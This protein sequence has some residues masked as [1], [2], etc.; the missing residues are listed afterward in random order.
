MNIFD[1]FILIVVSISTFY[2]IRYGLIRAIF[3]MLGIIVGWLLAGQLSGL[4]G[5]YLSGTI[6]NESVTTVIAYAIILILSLWISSYAYKVLMPVLTIS[7]LGMSSL[8][9]KLGGALLGLAIGIT[10]SGV[11]L[12]GVARVAYALDLDKVENPSESLL[13]DFNNSLAGLETN[14][15][16]S[17]FAPTVLKIFE[18]LPGTLPNEFEGAIELFKVGVEYNDLLNSR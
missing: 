6:T 10:I 3:S 1:W 18:K 17:Q 5:G 7:T 11:C 16:N 12:T 8:I 9:N 2:G 15:T 14:L 13:L 4:I